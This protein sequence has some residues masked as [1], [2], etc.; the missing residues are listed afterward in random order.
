MYSNFLTMKELTN[1]NSCS[2]LKHIYLSCFNY[3]RSRN[4]PPHECN[5]HLKNYL[6]YLSYKKSLSII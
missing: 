3:N 5:I 4:K 6:K 2:E 1:N